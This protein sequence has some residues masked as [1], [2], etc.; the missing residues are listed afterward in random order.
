MAIEGH[1]FPLFLTGLVFFFLGLDGVRVGLKGLAS[2]SVRRRAQAVVASPVR[3]AIVGIGFGALSQSATAVSMVLSGLVSTGL[4]PMRR[5]L[6]VVAWANPGTAILAFL[7]AINLTAA[8]LWLIG[9]VGL[10]MRQKRLFAMRPVLGAVLGIGFMLFGLVLLKSTTAPAQKSAWFASA[11]GALGSSFLLAFAAG[12]FLRVVIQ[13]SSGITVI[14]IA[15]AS[16][17]VLDPAHAMMVVHGTSIGVGVSVLL[18]GGGLRGE[19]LRIA[20]YQAIV[21]ALAGL[22]LGAWAIV[23]DVTGAPD[24]VAILGR[25]HLGLETALATGFL[26]QMLLC[27]LAATIIG[28]RAES[29]L[30]RLAPESEEQGL[31]R[32]RYL[33]EGATE[34][35]EVALELVAKESTR[36]LEATP[37]LL[38]GARLDAAAARGLDAATLAES[39]V[40]LDSEIDGF[41][42]ELLERENTHETA[43]RALAAGA[44]QRALGE[45]ASN[46]AELAAAVAAIPADSPS[47]MLGGL[48]VESLDAM[49]RTAID[50]ARDGAEIDRELLALMTADRGEQMEAVRRGAA[51][52]T[53]GSA[54]EQAQILYATSLFERAVYLLRTATRAHETD[55]PGNPRA[56]G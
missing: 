17:G 52:G 18:L 40:A 30:A 55:T 9:L 23:A 50:V 6:T 7:A 12:A 44:R 10:A 45:L 14:L 3:A 21:N 25:L 11:S 53:T 33:S 47:R 39:L 1:A 24:L 38:D 20:Y 22:A 31:A 2:R 37:A 8:T 41:L 28:G 36:F 34:D 16:R 4:I 5:A 35:P 32:L 27:P 56:D 15:L 49:L 29:I 46:L 43:T 51:V 54:R 26:V 19:A 13:S 42:A 48:L